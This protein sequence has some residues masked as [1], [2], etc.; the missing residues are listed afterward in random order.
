MTWSSWI[1]TKNQSIKLGLVLWPRTGP[2]KWILK[3]GLVL[4]WTRPGLAI[5]LNII[6]KTGP[7]SQSRN[8]TG[9]DKGNNLRLVKITNARAGAYTF[10]FSCVTTLCTSHS[11]SSF[12]KSFIFISSSCRWFNKDSCFLSSSSIAGGLSG[13]SNDHRELTGFNGGT[14][15][16]N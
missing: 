16:Q 1:S 8:W 13:S 15:L 11:C 10:L 14:Y 7:F 9:A 5:P 6:L 4:Y 2:E 12:A 3:C